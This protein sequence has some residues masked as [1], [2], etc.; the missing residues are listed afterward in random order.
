MG[1]HA[2]VRRKFFEAKDQSPKLIGW[3]LRQLS[4]LYR[5]EKELR[6]ARAAP[7]IREVV[8]ASQSTII[9]RRL[10]IIL[11]KLA[12]RK[13]AQAILP[14]SGLGKAIHY[15][16]NQWPHL[17]TY[18]QDGRVE[19]DNNL[20][21]NAIRPSKLGAKNWL[22]IG[23]EASGEKTAILYTIVENCRR[24]KIDPREY[25]EDVLT[26]LP[27]LKTSEVAALT[28]ANWKQSKTPKLARP[29]AA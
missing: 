8:R 12:A 21:E 18:L 22:F 28:P 29:K 27:D 1:C 24:E 16:L 15:A 5:I 25:L 26:R 9:H 7:V 17:Q 3:I 14:Q 11:E 20:C 13:G 23:N 19:I 4:H 6:V 10:K 2:H